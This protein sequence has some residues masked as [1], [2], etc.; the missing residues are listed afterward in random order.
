MWYVLPTV[1]EK[2]KMKCTNL[3]AGDG[4]EPHCHCLLLHLKVKT[5]PNSKQNSML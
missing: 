5:N 1:F 4:W 3:Y 2:R